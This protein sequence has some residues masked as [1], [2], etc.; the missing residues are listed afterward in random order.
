M[1]WVRALGLLLVFSLR[2]LAKNL[3]REEVKFCLPYNDI[4]RKGRYHSGNIDDLN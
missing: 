4:E 1:H 3:R 2:V